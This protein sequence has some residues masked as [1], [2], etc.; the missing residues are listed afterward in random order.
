MYLV[1]SRESSQF[2][3]Q[4]DDVLPLESIT[5]QLNA[6]P[7]MSCHPHDGPS[8]SSSNDE[9]GTIDGREEEVGT[10]AA[11]ANHSTA[12]VIG[13]NHSNSS[14]SNN[15]STLHQ[16]TPPPSNNGSI[17]STNASSRQINNKH[18]QQFH[19]NNSSG[20]KNNDE[21]NNNNIQ[22][23]NNDSHPSPSSTIDSPIN[24]NTAN[25]NDND[26][27]TTNKRA[28]VQTAIT[29]V[30][31]VV[32][33]VVSSAI[34]FGRDIIGDGKRRKTNNNNKNNQVDNDEVDN[35]AVGGNDK[36]GVAGSALFASGD[37]VR[38]SIGDA[39]T[40]SNTLRIQSNNVEGGQSS[41][42][43][44]TMSST[45]R[46]SSNNNAEGDQPSGGNSRTRRYDDKR[47]YTIQHGG[48]LVVRG[49]STALVCI[50][51]LLSMDIVVLLYKVLNSFSCIY[52]FA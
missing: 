38:R 1:P 32:S 46:I 44:G 27:P 40:T 17:K 6:K 45:I 4:K 37:S 52:Y 42:E 51:L 25:K 11:T 21:N 18:Q 49:E 16:T 28:F 48:S 19:N 12:D 29:Y 14:S 50:H 36:S 7:R 3:R 9:S 35:N 41:G 10:A 43:D 2:I 5:L 39:D 22:N 24:N 31:G 26:G 23:N 30:G 47:M 33:N 15:E 8:Q 20:I 34:D 13:N